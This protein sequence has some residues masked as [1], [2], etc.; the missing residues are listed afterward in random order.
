MKKLFVVAG[1]V[2]TGLVLAAH[3]ARAVAAGKRPPPAAALAQVRL[4][5]QQA[6]LAL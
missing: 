6:T 1:A 2:C 4:Q 5:A 3:G